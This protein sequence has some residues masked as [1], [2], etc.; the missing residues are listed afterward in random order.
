MD[1]LGKDLT[2]GLGELVRKGEDGV[3]LPSTLQKWVGSPSL[4]LG[5]PVLFLAVLRPPCSRRN[6]GHEPGAL[7]SRL[8]IPPLMSTWRPALIPSPPPDP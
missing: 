5:T 2:S 7:S 4:S 1:A 6:Q 8:R 3:S